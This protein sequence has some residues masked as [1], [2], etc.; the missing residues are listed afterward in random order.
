MLL[1]LMCSICDLFTLL[2]LLSTIPQGL[3]AHVIHQQDHVIQ[4]IT[5]ST[6]LVHNV[7]LETCE[8]ML[9]N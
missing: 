7:R 6:T 5:R 8:C 3:I 4:D 2:V 9:I 1:F